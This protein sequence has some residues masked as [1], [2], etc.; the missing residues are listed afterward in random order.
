VTRLRRVPGIRTRLLPVVL[1]AALAVLP[2]GPAGAQSDAPAGSPPELPPAP[3]A[4]ARTGTVSF[5]DLYHAALGFHESVGEATERL[6]QAE[7]ERKKVRA[8]LLPDLDVTGTVQRRPKNLTAGGSFLVASK[9]SRDLTVTLGQTL[10]TGGRA[11]TQL[12]IATIGELARQVDLRLTRE[13]LVYNV[14]QAVFAVSKAQADLSSASDRREGMERHLQAAQARVRLG[15]DVRATALR[16]E[17]EVARLKA[18]EMQA[19]DAL[20]TARENLAE[21]TGLPQDVQLGPPPDMGPVRSAPDPVQTALTHRADVALATSEAAAAKL[22]VRYT[23]GTFLPVIN[24]TGT[25]TRSDENPATT[26]LIDEESFATLKATWSLFNGGEDVAERHRAQAAFR[27]KQLNLTELQR[28]IHTQVDQ[29][30][31]QVQVAEQVVQS[32][33]DAWTYAAENHRIV[34]ETFNVGAATYLDVIDASTA[35]G[36]AR[37]DLENARND[38]N[39]ALLNLAQDTG[40]LLALVGESVPSS[41]DLDS[42]V[43]AKR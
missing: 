41:G 4:A 43:R 11:R 20:K 2:A 42:W 27:E 9:D 28:E 33:K 19:S 37:R 24:L 12:K 38:L 1:G 36:D 18:E 34:T 31:R 39:L 25:Y 6:R 26:F 10:Y 21:L 5:A 7:Y 23:S 32:L 15:A 30:E 22:G 35:L 8:N 29:A 3:S 16:L 13:T 14:A 17:S 40:E